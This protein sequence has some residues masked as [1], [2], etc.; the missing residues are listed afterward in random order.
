MH[1]YGAFLPC[2]IYGL[3]GSSKQLAVG[4][5]AV[6]S[7]L[8]F[9]GLE[10][11]LPCH[12]NIQKYNPPYKSIEDAECMAQY[13]KAAIQL[14]F[15]VACFYTGIGVLQLGWCVARQHLHRAPASNAGVSFCPC[16][17]AHPLLLHA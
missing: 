8:I 9:S 10:G 3:V 13:S 5:V 16:P 17:S 14:A 1:R 15:I 7:L 11:I 4:P 2:M 12:N 6:T